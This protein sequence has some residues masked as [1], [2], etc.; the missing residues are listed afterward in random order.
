MERLLDKNGANRLNGFFAWRPWA[1]ASVA[2]L[3]FFT[4]LGSA[5]LWDEDEPK[6]ARCGVEMYERGDWI[7]PTYNEELRSHK[8]VLLYW[9]MIASYTFLGVGEFAARTPSAVCGVL[10]TVMC[11]H[12]GR[13]LFDRSTG[14]VAALLLSSALMFAILARAAT[15]DGVLMLC[16]TGALLA[17]VSG[18]AYRR[19]GSFSGEGAPLAEMQLAWP[20]VVAMYT[21]M[22][23]GVLAKG[24]IGFAIPLLAIVLYGLFG[25]V[26]GMKH[27]EGVGQLRRFIGWFLSSISLQRWASGA[28]SIRLLSGLAI[29]AAI[30]GPWYLAVSMQTSGDWLTGFIGT[31]NVGRFMKPMEGHN[32][33]IFYYVVTILLLF[34]PGSCFLPVAVVGATNQRRTGAEQS[35]SAAFT[36]A[37]LAAWIGFFSLAA[38]KLP[39][40]IVPCYIGAALATAAWLVRAARKA[41]SLEIASLRS[42]LAAGMGSCIASGVAIAIGLAIVAQTLMGGSP[43]LGLVG[44][45]PIAGGA[46]G[47]WFLREGQAHRAVAAFVTCSLL[48]TL[49]AMSFVAPAA[50]PFAD[51]PRLADLVDEIETASGQRIQFATYHYTT[52]SLVWELGRHVPGLNSEEALDVLA[53]TTAVVAMP[54]EDYENLKAELPV[55]VTKL[56]E[57]GRF[58]RRHKRVVLVGHQ[59]ALAQGRL[60]RE[61]R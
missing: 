27:S 15:P 50:S 14:L 37:Y 34:F 46:L 6:N 31:H 21:A 22:G 39:N 53:E 51:G 3:L 57:E 4:N 52:P 26:V 2:A 54:F 8:P 25:E 28:Q 16:T 61:L 9:A 42:W 13:L 7:V 10:I 44:L 19:G 36:L 56:A 49:S 12:M 1:V 48:F 23:F 24:P 20:H 38:T 58:M 18:V 33:P 43:W 5:R 40:Y 60:Q 55:G 45:A 17:F 41:E 30:A 29:V 47:L 11:Y 59:E 32:G 35:A